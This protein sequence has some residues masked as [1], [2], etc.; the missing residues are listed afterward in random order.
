MRATSRGTI[1]LQ[2]R[3]PYEHPLIDPNYL[4]TEEDI[5]DMRRCVKRSREIFAQKAFDPFRGD[6]LQPGMLYGITHPMF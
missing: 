2:S 3:N 1:R 6:E 4:A 5:V